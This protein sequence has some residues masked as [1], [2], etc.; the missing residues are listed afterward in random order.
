MDKPKLIVDPI[1]PFSILCSIATV[2]SVD[3]PAVFLER[4][5]GRNS[6]KISILSEFYPEILSI[7]IEKGWAVESSTN[8]VR[9]STHERRTILCRYE[10]SWG[11]L[12]TLGF[13]TVEVVND[14]DYTNFV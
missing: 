3:T 13:V 5:A 11:L 12:R 10:D 14:H 2:E 8:L 6:R 1:N 7:R 4:F 9:K